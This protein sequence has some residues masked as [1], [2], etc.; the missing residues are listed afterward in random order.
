MHITWQVR[1]RFF[2][3]LPTV[4]ATAPPMPESA[5][6]NI[7]T[8]PPSSFEMS[9]LS[10]SIMR[11]SSPPEATLARDLGDSSGFAENRNDTSSIPSADMSF[12]PITAS[13]RAPLMPT[14]RSQEH[15]SELQSQSNL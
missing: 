8:E 14:S 7:I 4:S 6:S 15:T 1:E 11:E 3:F 12:S 10:T 9:S 13:N 5:S 2:I